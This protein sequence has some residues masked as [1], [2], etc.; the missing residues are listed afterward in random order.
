MGDFLP[1]PRIGVATALLL[2]NVVGGC[3]SEGTSRLV[4]TPVGDILPRTVDEPPVP[5]DP[6]PPKPA[7]PDPIPP[8]PPK[9]IPP[10]PPKPEPPE[11]QEPGR[12]PG[13]DPVCPSDMVH[14]AGDYCPV[15]R[16]RCLEHHPE[17]L[18]RR[19]DPTVSERCLRYQ[20]PSE[21]SSKE[22]R[23]LSYC[24][25]RFEY[26]GTPG[27][28]PR[29]LTSWLE[30]EKLCQARGRR[31]CTE[32]EFNFA[33]EGPDMLPY[34]TGFVRDEAACNI[35]RP[36]RLPDHSHRMKTYDACP[37]D[38]FC[39][40]E[41]E[42]LDQRHAIGSRTT[43]VSWSGVVDLNGNVNE[44]VS[45]VGERSPDRSGLKGGWW[46][47]VRNR[48]RPTVRFHKENDYGYEAGFRCCQDAK[49][50]SEATP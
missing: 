44:W 48:C 29:V 6:D 36:Y 43:C 22:R 7:P 23:P 2:A 32:D 17:Y 40:A 24:M 42:R 15:V 38:A 3:K 1:A 33:C 4:L 34:A 9:P 49:G 50:A 10:R 14:V 21:C 47:P 16:Q 8:R 37:D 27:A 13:E 12:D 31:L 5:P 26:P 39:R 18:A 45:I 46:G 28:L 30:A 35:D 25:D 11:P 41:L 20:S 19:G